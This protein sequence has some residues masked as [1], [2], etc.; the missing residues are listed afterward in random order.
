MLLRDFQQHLYELVKWSL[1]CT[2]IFKLLLKPSS[3]V[4]KYWST[5]RF[6]LHFAS[7]TYLIGTTEDLLCQGC[8]CDAE[9]QKDLWGRPWELECWVISVSTSL[10][11]SSL[12]ISLK[13]EISRWLLK[14]F[15]SAM[16]FGVQQARQMWM[17]ARIDS[18]LLSCLPVLI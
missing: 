8:G 9:S 12:P 15:W 1:K 13:L 5:R 18:I 17:F 16:S 11:C 10:I 2:N 14:S 7:I 6:A 3:Y 4:L